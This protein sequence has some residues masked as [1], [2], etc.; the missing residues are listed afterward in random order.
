LYQHNDENYEMPQLAVSEYQLRFEP[1]TS[2]TGVRSVMPE[3]TKL[4][5]TT[6]KVEV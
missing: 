4:E 2:K 1:C 3:S 5:K 6:R